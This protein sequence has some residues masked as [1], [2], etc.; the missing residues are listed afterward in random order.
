MAWLKVEEVDVGTETKIERWFL[1]PED[2]SAKSLETPNES[3][4]FHDGSS[5]P[6]QY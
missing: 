6:T 1:F 2:I 3:K 4:N 5:S